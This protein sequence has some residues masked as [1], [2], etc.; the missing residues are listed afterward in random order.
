[1][2]SIRCFRVV[3]REGITG[4]ENSLRKA[5]EKRSWFGESFSLSRYY[6]HMRGRSRSGLRAEGRGFEMSATDLGPDSVVQGEV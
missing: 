1:M 3:K 5:T 2:D 6:I 4:R